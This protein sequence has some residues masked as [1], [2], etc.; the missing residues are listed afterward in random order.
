[1][2]TPDAEPEKGFYYRSDHFN[3]A[4]AGVPALHPGAGADFIGRPAAFGKQKR[5]EWTSTDY[6]A[7][8]DEVKD[9]WDL[10]G[11]AEDATLLFAVGYRVANADRYPEWS[12]GNEFRAIRQKALGR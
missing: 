1:V 4:K 3:F 11:A 2:L 10:S 8:S 6:H 12:A 7:P 5:D 9:W